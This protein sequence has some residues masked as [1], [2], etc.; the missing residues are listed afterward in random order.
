MSKDRYSHKL[1][2]VSN[3]GSL[4]LDLVERGKGVI[5]DDSTEGC[6]I[7]YLRT[8]IYL[9]L[10]NRCKLLE[11]SITFHPQYAQHLRHIEG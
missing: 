6:L 3:L 11:H 7:Y 2:D 8:N 10:S 9:Q 5:L 4:R 1:L